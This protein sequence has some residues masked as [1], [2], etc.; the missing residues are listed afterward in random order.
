M[1]SRTEQIRCLQALE[2]EY[3]DMIQLRFMVK[4]GIRKPDTALSI[5]MPS[6]H[7][8]MILED[9]VVPRILND[10]PPNEKREFEKLLNRSIDE[11]IER[12]LP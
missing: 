12:E 2:R 10:C 1:T 8:R 4:L 11:Y 6:V 9:Y 7:A 5:E 3:M